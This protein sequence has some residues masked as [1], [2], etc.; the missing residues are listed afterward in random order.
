MA[1]NLTET[2][3]KALK[4]KDKL[5]Q[6][7]DAEG[8]VI[9]VAKSGSKLWR[10]RYRYAGK[11]VL[12]ALGEYPAIGLKQARQLRDEAK[13]LLAMGIDPRQKKTEKK[14]QQIAE[15]EAQRITSYTFRQAYQD[16]FDFKS[17]EWSD[18]YIGDVAGRA[19]MY[20]LP[21][22]ADK[23]L[24]EIT[25]KD[26]IIALKKI[27]ELGRLGAMAKCKTI[28]TSI[29]KYHVSYSNIV[30][31]PMATLD[32]S[33]LQKAEKKNF[34]HLTTPAEIQATYAKLAQPYKG[35][36]I[37]HDAA[38][39]L[40]LTFLRASEVA[41]LK[42]AHVD[43]E[44][45]LIRLPASAMKMNREHLVPIS[46]QVRAILD[47]RHDLRFQSDYVFYSPN[48]LTK[49]INP[50]SMR[51]VLRLQ[52]IGADVL[53]SHGWRHSASTWLH[54]K[55]F[56]HWAIEQQLS[57]SK[58]GVSAAYDKSQHLQERVKMMQA[59]ADFITTE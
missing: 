12:M 14:Q 29:F 1:N 31:S 7:A 26:C 19:R 44:H 45:N 6:V 43:F 13:A 59:W 55:G 56:D 23:A 54:E 35:S 58:E 25:T 9:E 8:L 47:R 46:E 15:A 33:I 20:L 24:N 42:W 49:P 34:A 21:S 28:L 36:D 38:K 41:R 30:T 48:D 10:L 57:H 11:S 2:Q 39:M 40:A 27:E 53:T 18:G 5:Y 32:G 22:L 37:V 51:K 50:E 4:P 3:I 17:K 16:W 52:G